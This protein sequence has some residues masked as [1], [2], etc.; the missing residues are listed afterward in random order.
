[1]RYDSSKLDALFARK[2]ALQREIEEELTARKQFISSAAAQ[3]DRDRITAAGLR[4]RKL[5]KIG[6]DW[7]KAGKIPWDSRF[8]ISVSGN[9]AEVAKLE[10]QLR[11][12]LYGG[13]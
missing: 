12:L 13:V 5:Q 11:V 2:K 7:S 4:I 9:P 10:S 8:A 3:S 6:T 1:V